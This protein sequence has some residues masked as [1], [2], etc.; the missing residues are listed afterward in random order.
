MTYAR[1]PVS[2]MSAGDTSERGPMRRA[3]VAGVTRS[4]SSARAGY[5]AADVVD[6]APRHPH[7]RRCARGPADPP[8]SPSSSPAWAALPQ[9]RRPPGDA[10]LRRAVGRRRRTDEG[11]SRQ[12]PGGPSP[13]TRGWVPASAS[14]SVTARRARSCMPSR[15][16][17]LAPPRR[18]SRSC[19]AFA[20]TPHLDLDAHMTTRV[21]TGRLA[22]RDRPRRRRRHPPRPGRRTPLGRGPR[23][24]RHPRRRGRAV[25]RAT[26]PPAGDAARRR[27]LRRRPALSPT[28]KK[29][30]IAAGFTQ[31]VSML[32]LV[33]QRAGGGRAG[34]RPV[35]ES[36]RGRRARARRST[37]R[38][39]ADDGGTPARPR[40]PGTGRR[41]RARRGGARR[42]TPSTSASPCSTATTRSPRTS[43]ARPWSPRA[44][45]R[46]PRSA[47]RS[48]SSRPSPTPACPPQGL[49]L[50]DTSGLVAGRRR[51]PRRRSPT[52]SRSRRPARTPRS[53]GPSSALP[54]AGLNGSLS[55]R[56]RGKQTKAVAGIP[57]AKTG[58]L[59][60]ISS[61]AGTT[62]DADGHAARLRRPRRSCASLVGNAGRTRGV[63]SLRHRTDPVRMPLGGHVSNS[64]VD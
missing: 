5:A 54:V 8:G 21:V 36:G 58:T 56:Y 1:G 26:A 57:R 4:S 35:P 27:D 18:P 6:L 15:P 3:A 41:D 53:C 55:D 32:D 62:V 22:E 39:H 23:R 34:R 25:A 19:S 9:R 17:S 30:D 45:H 60:G 33:S 44:R 31:S 2:R 47:R 11:R 16:A 48:S 12:G 59:K 28:W 7:L 10:P 37:A 20:V 40:D 13:R 64:Y 29:E 43:S 38:G 14:A 61:L 46:R 63:G 42:P 52:C 50:L 51:R 49:R 24:H